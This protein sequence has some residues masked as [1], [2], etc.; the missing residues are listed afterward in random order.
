MRKSVTA[1][2]AY[3]V[4]IVLLGAADA[5]GRSDSIGWA[6]RERPGRDRTSGGQAASVPAARGPAAR[7]PTEA[8]SPELAE[9][10][11]VA[12]SLQGLRVKAME[13]ETLA[14]RWMT[15]LSEVDSRVAQM[16]E[17]KRELVERQYEIEARF[18]E[19]EQSGE[20]I[21]EKERTLLMQQYQNIQSTLGGPRNEV[22]A[23]PEFARALENFK[24]ALYRKMRDLEPQLAAEVDR[25]ELLTE[26]LY[27]SLESVRPP[28]AK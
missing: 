3:A 26:Q 17:L 12:K 23:Q 6:D 7:G 20:E 19:A 16:D 18:A 24:A 5:C 22:F 13:D 27:Q 21:A 2:S 9:Y 8:I 25:L 1:L 4:F 14:A 11:R 10:Q 28:L 15:L